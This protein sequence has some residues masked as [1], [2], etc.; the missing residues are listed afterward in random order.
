MSENIT[1]ICKTLWNSY[2]NIFFDEDGHIYVNSNGQRYTSVTKIIEQYYPKFDSKTIAPFTAKKMSAELGR[3]V[4]T[5]EVLEIWK[6]KNE[7][8]KI[9]GTHAH[10]VMENL[11]AHK[12]Y[13]HNFTEQ[14]K[15]DDINADFSRR[16][17]V[18]QDLYKKLSERYIPI[19]NELIIYDESSMLCGCIDFL[20]YDTKHDELVIMDWKTNFEIK[21]VPQKYTE[22]MYA[23]FEDMDDLTINH[24]YIQLSMYKAILEKTSGLKVG[25]MWLFHITPQCQIVHYKVTDV[26]DICR[27]YILNG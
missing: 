26:S 16:K 5:E 13:K 21:T 6:D 25:S 3:T 1:D 22:K 11:W 23:P 10:L 15:I 12:E 8:A 19:K 4:T 27:K 9:F 20:A 2:K 7:Y 24:Y 17:P 18:I 14:F